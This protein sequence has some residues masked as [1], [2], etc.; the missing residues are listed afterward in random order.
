MHDVMIA[1]RISDGPNTYFDR[2]KSINC[3]FAIHS[4]ECIQAG[5]YSF[6]R[7]SAGQATGSFMHLDVRMTPNTLHPSNAI[8]SEGS[9]L[10][11]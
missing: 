1:M 5:F 7:W 2:F 10:D 8:I 11:E 9:I 6:Q 3:S 4:V